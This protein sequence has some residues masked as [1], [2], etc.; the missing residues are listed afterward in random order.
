M[1]G[2]R[3][4]TYDTKPCRNWEAGCCWVAAGL[5][6]GL[7]CAGAR[8]TGAARTARLGL[9]LGLGLGLVGSDYRSDVGRA[10]RSNKVGRRLLARLTGQTSDVSAGGARPAR[11]CLPGLQIRRQTCQPTSDVSADIRQAP[12]A[13]PA[14]PALALP[15]LLPTRLTLLP[16]RP[17]PLPT[18][19]APPTPSATRPSLPRAH[20]VLRSVS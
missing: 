18:R 19:P 10:H 14:R 3:F 9:G 7:G 15:T 4:L 13:D 17:N 16:T 12:S 1:F 2:C 20:R 8:V 11:G 5:L 6:L